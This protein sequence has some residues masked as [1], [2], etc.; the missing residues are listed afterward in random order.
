MNKLASSSEGTTLTQD[1]STPSILTPRTALSPDLNS[2]AAKLITDFAPGTVDDLSVV[3][4]NLFA[5]S[6]EAMLQAEMDQHLGYSK[7]SHVEKESANRR[8]GY[9]RKTVKTSMGDVSIGTP[10]DRDGSFELQVIAKRQ[11]NV[12]DVEEV[13][14]SLYAKGLSVRDIADAVETIYGYHISHTEISAIT[15][16]VM[17]TVKEWQNRPLRAL[18]ISL[19]VDCV[20]VSIKTPTG[21]KDHAVY[22]IIVISADGVKDILGFWIAETESKHTWM[23]IFDE[24]KARGVQD[25]LFICMDGVTGLEDGAKAVFPGVTVQRCM[26]HLIRNSRK[27]IPTKSQA[28]FTAQAK[29]LYAS[30]SLAFA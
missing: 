1:Q 24:I 5:T 4:K 22:V 26:V 10:R 7:G 21:A 9:T 25:V 29:L 19:F 18:Y 2:L 16:R 13:V 20:Y 12:H 11:V 8:N 17:S 6:I 23:N 30:P 28:A 14:L 27:Y 3:I 15:E